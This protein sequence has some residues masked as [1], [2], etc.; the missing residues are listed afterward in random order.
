MHNIQVLYLFKL[1]NRMRFLKYLFS[2]YMRKYKRIY[3]NG[4]NMICTN[5]STMAEHNKIYS[6]LEYQDA[7]PKK[8]PYR[9][10]NFL[11]KGFE[12]IED[13]KDIEE[14]SYC[15]VCEKPLFVTPENSFCLNLT[16]HNTA[17]PQRIAN[18]IEV[19]LNHLGIQ[20]SESLKAYLKNYVIVN[21]QLTIIDL[22]M[23]C[24]MLPFLEIQNLDNLIQT[25][26]AKTFLDLINLYDVDDSIADQIDLLYSSAK[27]LITVLLDGSFY[28]SVPNTTVKQS[29]FNAA[30][31]LSSS[32]NREFISKYSLFCY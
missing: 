32:M 2:I 21:R 25:S 19:Q 18:T 9:K 31:Y 30:L 14:H 13:H 24:K 15:P 29:L 22:A 23:N 16:C 6:I 12:H 8:I 11:Y 27:E 28:L 5:V 1:S 4:E 7:P 10:Y 17:Y 20:A 3:L 26:S